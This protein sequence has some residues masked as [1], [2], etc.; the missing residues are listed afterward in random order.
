MAE[1]K[2]AQLIRTDAETFISHLGDVDL[3]LG[4]LTPAETLEERTGHAVLEAL[5]DLDC[6]R[7]IAWCTD[8][9]YEELNAELS[10][11]GVPAET[12][13]QVSAFLRR[14]GVYGHFLRRLNRSNQGYDNELTRLSSRPCLTIFGRNPILTLEFYSHDRLVLSSNNSLDGLLTLIDMLMDTVHDT[15][16]SLKRLAPDTVKRDLDVETLAS[17][18]KQIETLQRAVESEGETKEQD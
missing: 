14:Y 2:F 3:L 11:L 16:E 18:A 6:L 4:K 10:Q 1:D 7:F 15:V 13:S 8:R 9:D 17:L 5:D 12:I